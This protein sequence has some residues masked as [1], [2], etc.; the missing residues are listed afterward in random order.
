MV[1]RWS[2]NGRIS[3]HCEFHTAD[4]RVARGALAR[5]R[6]WRAAAARAAGPAA[7]DAISFDSL[8]LRVHVQL[9][10]I[11]QRP[12]TRPAS[13]PMTHPRGMVLKFCHSKLH[14]LHATKVPWPGHS[15]AIRHDLRGQ[16]GARTPMGCVLLVWAL[17]KW[18]N[19]GHA[20]T[21]S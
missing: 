13:P 2:R 9:Y 1:A 12:R 21:P 8:S 6:A 18:P 5:R 15:K 3:L 7:G 11:M 16:P 17:V 4:R 14:G 10:A 19:E 20:Q